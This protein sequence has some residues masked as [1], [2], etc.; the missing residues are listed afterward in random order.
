M[1][2]DRDTTDDRRDGAAGVRP[3]RRVPIDTATAPY[4]PAVRSAST[5]GLW[6]LVLAGP[7]LWIVHFWIVYLSAEASC[8]ADAAPEMSFIGTGGTATLTIVATMVGVVL[9]GVAAVGCHRRSSAPAAPGLL[10]AGT[11]LALL[12]GVAIFL[13]GV[14]VLAL[15]LCGP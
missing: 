13:V 12:S 14:P 7:G 3:R 9:C 10:R 4:E 8:A 6:I 1:S 15:P 5:V 2:D 11:L